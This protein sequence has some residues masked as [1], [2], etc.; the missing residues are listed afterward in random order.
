MTRIIADMKE[1]DVAV[2]SGPEH[3]RC[4]AALA[5]F[6]FCLPTSDIVGVADVKTTV[7]HLEDVN[8]EGHVG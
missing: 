5:M 6:V 2:L 1:S 7:V 3:T 8:V 4:A